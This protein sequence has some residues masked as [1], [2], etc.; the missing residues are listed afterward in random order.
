MSAAAAPAPSPDLV[1]GLGASAGGL[2]ALQAFFAALPSDAG[3]AYVVVQHL[4]PAG[5]NLLP[6]LLAKATPLPVAEALAAHPG[7]ADAVVTPVSDEEFGQRLQAF[8]VP[9]PASEV[10]E[11]DLRGWLRSRLS[12]AEQPRDI[13]LVDELPRTA[14]GKPVAPR[15]P[16]P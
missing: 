9:R 13:V 15:A 3:L 6:E 1:V 14:T 11:E 4:D 12:R 5:P 16:S 8:V 7:V 2:E 10:S